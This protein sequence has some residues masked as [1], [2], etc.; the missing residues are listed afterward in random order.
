MRVMVYRKEGG[1]VDVLIVSSPARKL[2]PVL[3]QDVSPA[4]RRKRVLDAILAVKG[5]SVRPE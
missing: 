3:V 1:K 5:A 4:D 2:P